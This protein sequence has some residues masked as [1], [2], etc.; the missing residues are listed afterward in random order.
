[1]PDIETKLGELRRKRGLSAI[2]L[3]ATVGVSRQTIYAIEA[4]TY[5]PNTA[6]A[7][8]LARALDT[9]VEE[10]FAVVDC[11]PQADLRSE[12]SVLLP[13]S[14]TP[15]AGQA[16]QLC[17]VDKKLTASAPSAVSW[18]FPH[19]CGRSKAARTQRQNAC[20]DPS[21]EWRFRESDLGSRL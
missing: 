12:P 13:G 10:V 9:T 21:V 15:Q 19:G 11:A 17:Q 6:V 3:A 20:A 1:M 16:V 8:L 4:G 14:E 5:V 2:Q 7:L 18:Y